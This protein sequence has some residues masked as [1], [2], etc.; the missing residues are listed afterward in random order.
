M[1]S[2]TLRKFCPHCGGHQ[3]RYLGVDAAAEILDLTPEAV[4]SMIRRRELPF[5]KLGTR[6]RLAYSDLESQLVR[7][8]SKGE[9]SLEQ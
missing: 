3:E 4:R 8:P 7:Y 1:T 6:L 9:V 2:S 5:F